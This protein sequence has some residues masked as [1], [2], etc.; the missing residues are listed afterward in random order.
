[1][2][3]YYFTPK[4]FPKLQS[5][6]FSTCSKYQVARTM[7]TPLLLGDGNLDSESCLCP[8]YLFRQ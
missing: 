1:M 5:T 2:Y 3:H 6:L 7:L 4:Q 8:H